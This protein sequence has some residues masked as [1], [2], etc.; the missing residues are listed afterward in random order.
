[1]KK[2]GILSGIS[3]VLILSIFLYG[4]SG[5]EAA[6]EEEKVEDKS[7]TVLVE[8]GSPAFTVAKETAEEFK[9]KTGYEVKIESVPYTGVYD[10]LKAEVASQAGA[11]DVATIDIL[12]FPALASGLLPIDDLITDEVEN[13]LFPGL[14]EGG[15]YQD[16]VYGMPVWTNAKNLIY[17]KDLFEDEQNKADFKEQYGYEL[18]PPTTWDQ[19]RDI[20]KFFTRDTDNDGK[21]D[22]Y[23][24]TVFGAN[25]GDT[26]ASWLDHAAQA[27]TESLVIDN[28]SGEVIVNTKPYVESLQFLTDMLNKDQSVPPGALEIASAETSELFWSGKSAMMIAWGHFYVPSN[29]PKQSDVAGKVGSAPMI[30]GSEGIGAVPGPWY[31]VIPNSSK[32]QEIAQTYLEFI[33]EKNELFMDALGV[34]ARKSVFEEYSAKEGYEHLEPLMTTLS[35]KQTQNRPEIKE[36]QQIES[37]ALI[38]AVAY[39]LSGE[40][41]PQEALD[42]AAEVIKG[43]IPP[44]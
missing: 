26:V 30:A 18:I 24:T 12:W 16:K 14:V 19:Y 34:A 7:L 23:G 28:E 37:E 13:D 27:G 39:A 43:I 9:E 10:K 31:Q 32:K 5:E 33:Y 38:P 4:C 36:W 40:K 11:F 41:T 44:K 29:D 6:V 1:M 21:M 25:N 17:R 2:K 42:W 8:G 22:M 15:S 35:A 20:A 3:F